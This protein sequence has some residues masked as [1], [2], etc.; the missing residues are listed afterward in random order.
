MWRLA[1]AVYL[2]FRDCFA[3]ISKCQVAC[4]GV[5]IL[6][7]GW[8]GE[9][10]KFVDWESLDGQLNTILETLLLHS[11]AWTDDIFMLRQLV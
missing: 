1:L 11:N 9:C 10:V 6:M 7:F 3:Q 8:F 4:M 5:Y 2:R